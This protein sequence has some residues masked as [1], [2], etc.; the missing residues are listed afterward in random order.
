MRLL[1]PFLVII[2]TF[3]PLVTAPAKEKAKEKP[4]LTI[5]TYS[6]FTS[7][8]GAGPRIAKEFEKKCDCSLRFISFNDGVSLLTR[9]KL[10]NKNTE[11]DIILGLDNNLIAEAQNTGLFAAH[12]LKKR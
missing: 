7:E 5:Y 3:M 11:A 6:S 1:A 8:W 12:G 10:E 4:T 9:I 2:L